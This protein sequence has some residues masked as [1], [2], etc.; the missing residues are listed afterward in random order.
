MHDIPELYSSSRNQRTVFGGEI[1]GAP[2]EEIDAGYI[3]MLGPGFELLSHRWNLARP[4]VH[5]QRLR[6]NV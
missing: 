3:L 5:L 4:P 6:V 2:V 1:D